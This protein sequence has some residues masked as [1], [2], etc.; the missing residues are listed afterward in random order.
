MVLRNPAKKETRSKEVNEEGY[1]S[2]CEGVEWNRIAQDRDQCW[3]VVTA[4]KSSRVP[5][6]TGS[7]LTRSTTVDAV[8]S[9]T[10][11]VRYNRYLRNLISS[12][13]P[14]YSPKREGWAG[15]VAHMEGVRNIQTY[16]NLK[17]NTRMGR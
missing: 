10:P 9:I 8:G 2:G 7:F 11:A 4:A 12:P 15:N 16:V 5:Q 3:T 13:I 14:T 6:K 17:D 1:F